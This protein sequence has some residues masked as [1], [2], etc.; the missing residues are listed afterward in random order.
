MARL[1]QGPYSPGTL[2]KK[3]DNSLPW[4][5]M[6]NAK[7]EDG[8]FAV[9][10]KTG[11]SDWSPDTIMADNFGF[12]IPSNAV[13]VSVL[14]DSLVKAN[15]KT[16]Y[17]CLHG[18]S[19]VWYNADGT[20]A[21]FALA[22][23]QNSTYGYT[24]ATSLQWYSNTVTY[25]YYGMQLT[26]GIVNDAIFGWE[27][28]F[29]ARPDGSWVGLTISLDCIEATVTYYVPPTVDATTSATSVAAYSASAGGNVSADGGDDVTGRGVVYGTSANPTTAGDK[30]SDGIGTGSFAS[31]L[32]GL[33][34]RTKYY[35]RAY[36]K[37][38]AGVSYGPEYNFTTLGYANKV[39]GLTNTKPTAINTIAISRV[40]KVSGV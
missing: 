1:T 6:N 34:P 37:N 4:T 38:N 9:R 32:T 30:T 27:V 15:A 28:G 2:A 39:D 29:L 25:G 21:A 17:Y 36:A 18:Y 40:G 5:D 13:V 11:S 22:R 24:L 23:A 7:V 31:S 19:Y 3:V 33:S 26:P 35:Y 8:S 14:F 16:T 10:S 12:T 20:P